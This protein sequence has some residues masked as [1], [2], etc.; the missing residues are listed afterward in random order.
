VD[1]RFVL[2][3]GIPAHRKL[4]ADQM[5]GFGGVLTSVIS[6]DARIGSFGNAL[7]EGVSIMQGVVITNGIS[8]GREA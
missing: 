6:D 1:N 5:L 8:V 2:G 3:T 4:L 7:L